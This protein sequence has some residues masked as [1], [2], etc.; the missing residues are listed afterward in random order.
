MHKLIFQPRCTFLLISIDVSWQLVHNMSGV[1]H[2][3]HSP[4]QAGLI[5]G[6]TGSADEQRNETYREG[7]SPGAGSAGNVRGDR[8]WSGSRG[9]R[10]GIGLRPHGAQNASADHESG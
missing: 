1:V 10:G 8:R 6:M 9:M 7:A 3:K 4:R 5:L 2:E